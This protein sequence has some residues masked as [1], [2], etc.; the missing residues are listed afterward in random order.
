MTKL[1]PYER[2]IMIVA[3]EHPEGTKIDV[4]QKALAGMGFSGKELEAITIVTTEIALLAK[5]LGV[6]LND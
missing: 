1:T 5:V 6:D 4:F 2:A 3:L